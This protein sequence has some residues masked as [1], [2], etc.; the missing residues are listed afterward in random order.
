MSTY[1]RS[2]MY[3]WQKMYTL[4]QLNI[5]W[6]WSVMF[7]SQKKLVYFNVKQTTH[8]RGLLLP[9]NHILSFESSPYEKIK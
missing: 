7:L 6:L 9:G 5:R 4:R 1:V 8:K 3:V 2:S